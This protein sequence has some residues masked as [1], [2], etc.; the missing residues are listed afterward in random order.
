M[1]ISSIF[2]AK[3]KENLRFPLNCE[4]TGISPFMNIVRFPRSL[5]LSKCQ[6][7]HYNN[8]ADYFR[9]TYSAFRQRM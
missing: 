8:F 9:Q 2:I 6:K 1:N 7:S 5:S 3:P 4:L